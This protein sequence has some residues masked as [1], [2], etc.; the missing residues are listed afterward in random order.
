MRRFSTGDMRIKTR[1]VVFDTQSIS[2]NINNRCDTQQ[3]TWAASG[4]SRVGTGGG[5][6]DEE[7]GE[8]KGRG[9]GEW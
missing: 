4:G 9:V 8:G 5:G 2:K 7:E 3:K 6:R 1:S